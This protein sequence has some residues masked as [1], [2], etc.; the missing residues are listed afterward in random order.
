MKRNKI[1]AVLGASEGLGPA[2]IDYLLSRDQV[3]LVLAQDDPG[4]LCDSLEAFTNRYGLIDILIDN[5]AY[6][7]IDELHLSPNAKLEARIEKNLAII[8]SILPYMTPGPDG[9]IVGMPPVEQKYCQKLEKA[10]L[11]LDDKITY[12]APKSNRS[13]WRK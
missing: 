10:L 5:L 12:L 4:E 6:G 11:T 13:L 3:V 9:R 2:T 8:K 7:L 1:W